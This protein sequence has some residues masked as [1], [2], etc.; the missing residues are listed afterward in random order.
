MLTALA[1]GA[2]VIGLIA[3]VAGVLALRTLGQ[4]RRS[5]G[6][7]GRGPNG[8]RETFVEVAARQIEVSERTR[9]DFEE[10]S[11]AVGRVIES[12][13]ARVDSDLGAAYG[14]LRD[15]LNAVRTDADRRTADT[16][17][18]V[19]ARLDA[20][21]DV[22]DRELVDI[23]QRLSADTAAALDTVSTERSG[24]HDAAELQRR[25]LGELADRVQVALGA[26]LRR[27]ALVRFDAFDDLS[28]RLSFALALLDGRGDGIVLSSLAGR[29]ESRLYAKPVAGGAGVNDLSP[30]EQEAVTAAMRTR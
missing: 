24:L 13:R 15:E 16:A 8:R 11:R 25:Q 12:L 2:L 30:E 1:V 10:L 20:L 29:T 14:S 3:L 7:L 27:V 5:V 18:G 6:L 22:V 21:K 19:E 28:G 9:A 26:S 23:R 17:A 4:L